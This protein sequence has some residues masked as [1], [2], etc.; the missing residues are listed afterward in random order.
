MTTRNRLALFLRL[1]AAAGLVSLA[2]GDRAATA[3]A[4]APQPDKPAAGPAPTGLQ[5]RTKRGLRW[6]MGIE[7]IGPKDYLAK[8]QALGATIGYPKSDTSREIYL[9]KGISAENP[10]A[11]LTT[12]RAINQIFWYFTDKKELE[13]L[14]Q[15][16][17]IKPTPTALIVFFPQDLEERMLKL[18]LE[19]AEKAAGRPVK[20]EEIAETNFRVTFEG[21]QVKSI[22]VK[23]IKF[24]KQPGTPPPAAE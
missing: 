12:V 24:K 10:P 5:F 7:W 22:S 1:T 20:E 6:D 16:L 14:S 13:E 23:A 15:A 2:L 21:N 19:S 4:Q 8:L 11:E 18:E 3:R 9:L 17:G